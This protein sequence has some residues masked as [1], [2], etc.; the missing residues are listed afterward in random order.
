M[1]VGITSAIAPADMVEPNPAKTGVLT[2]LIGDGKSTGVSRPI[3]MRDEQAGTEQAESQ[4]TDYDRPRRQRRFPPCVEDRCDFQNAE[5]G[6]R[7]CKGHKRVKKTDLLM[8]ENGMRDKDDQ[9]DP[10]QKCATA[11]SHENEKNQR[12]QVRAQHLQIPIPRLH[13]KS[14]ARPS[15]T[16]TQK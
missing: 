10:T 9:R 3:E 6:E 12:T 13:A 5:R 2:E 7:D 14:L 8:A 4:A 11:N 1:Q 16:F 15:I